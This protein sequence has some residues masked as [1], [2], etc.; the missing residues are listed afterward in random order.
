M[1]LA[2][3]IPDHP[4]RSNGFTRPHDDDQQ[5]PKLAVPDALV[6]LIYDPPL[7]WPKLDFR[8][9]APYPCGYTDGKLS[10]VCKKN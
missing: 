8:G 10:H 5:L 4:P 6:G 1:T 9:I 7:V 3:S 2:D